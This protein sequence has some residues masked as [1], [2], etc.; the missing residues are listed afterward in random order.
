MAYTYSKIATYTVGSG[1]TLSMA[2]LNIPQNYTDLV[3][4]ISA[5]C[6]R[7]N[8]YQSLVIRPNGDTANGTSRT[9]E[10]NGA[11]ASSDTS[12]NILIQN[13]QGNVATQA[14]VF[15]SADVY[16]PNYTSSNYKSFS[17]DKVGENNATTAYADLTAS[18]WSSTAAITSLTII[19]GNL[20]YPIMQYSTFHL[21]GI[22]AEL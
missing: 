6:D 20:S 8:E 3:L 16:I 15:G 21:Y 22:K 12:A 10:G 5:K 7:P 14:N 11:T 2:F 19:T 17:I 13:L 4:K 9:L 18:L 1:G